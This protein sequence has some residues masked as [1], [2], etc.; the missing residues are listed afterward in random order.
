MY[1]ALV[2]DDVKVNQNILKALLQNNGHFEVDHASGTAEALHLCLL[3]PYDLVLLDLE[4]PNLKGDTFVQVIQELK[5]NQNIQHEISIVLCTGVED[6][7][8]VNLL[9]E[10]E[11]VNG[12]L[13]KPIR[14]DQFNRF[15]YQFF[16]E[17]QEV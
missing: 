9:L 13:Q 5:E 4:M 15:L 12:L 16:V 8:R 11:V 17:R 7:E 2:V 1:R 3:S 6:E 10:K 14:P